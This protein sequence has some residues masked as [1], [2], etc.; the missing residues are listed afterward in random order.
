MT[1]VPVQ[2]KII[3]VPAEWRLR[4]DE[5]S[6]VEAARTS[7]HGRTQPVGGPAVHEDSSLNTLGRLRSDQPNCL[8]G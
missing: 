7:S 1:A 2:S 4:D 5:L 3:S 8:D 6:L